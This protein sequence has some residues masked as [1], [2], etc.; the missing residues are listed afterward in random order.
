MSL[1][2]YIIDE[3]IVELQIRSL[4]LHYIAINGTAS[5]YY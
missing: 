5:N 4:L 2:I 3:I 1:H